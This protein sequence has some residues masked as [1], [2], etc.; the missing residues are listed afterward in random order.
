MGFGNVQPVDGGVT[1][2]V[3]SSGIGSSGPGYFAAIPTGQEDGTEYEIPVSGKL[4][5]LQVSNRPVG[6]DAVNVVYQ[7][8]VNKGNV[9]NPVILSAN[10]VGPVKVDLSSISVRAGDLV[11]LSMT[12][13]GGLPGAKPWSRVLFTY[14][15]STSVIS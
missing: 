10:A 14:T 15:P 3:L 8:R 13:L 11:S 6:A 2:Y 5:T 4:A 9:G 12:A 7:A 1:E